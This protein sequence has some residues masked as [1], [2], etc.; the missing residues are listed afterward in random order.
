MFLFFMLQK[1]LI[2]WVRGGSLFV[3]SCRAWRLS[4]HCSL[5]ESGKITCCQHSELVAPDNVSM[6]LLQWGWAKWVCTSFVNMVLSDV[7][8]SRHDS[9]HNKLGLAYIGWRPTIFAAGRESTKRG[10]INIG[11]VW[12]PSII[13][14]WLGLG[15]LF[16]EN[17]ESS[18]AI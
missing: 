4:T 16:G 18:V 12:S 10:W 11:K 7:K 1:W 15:P 3:K 13:S 6:W 17:D 5:C 9:E 8:V 14:N 2:F